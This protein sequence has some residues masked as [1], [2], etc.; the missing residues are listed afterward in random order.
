MKALNLSFQSLS[1]KPRSGEM[2]IEREPEL[3]SVKFRLGAQPE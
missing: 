3:K 1:E 2:F